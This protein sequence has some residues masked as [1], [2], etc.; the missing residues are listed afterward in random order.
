MATESLEKM[1]ST[2]F[3]APAKAVVEAER[4]YRKIWAEWLQMTAQ[5]VGA[6]NVG[7]QLNL[8]PVMKINGA[9]DLSLS[10]RVTS[11]DQTNASLSLG[12]GP[13]TVSGGYFRQTTEESSLS[14][15]GCFT[16]TNTEV[17]LASYLGQMG[18]TIK[19]DASCK[20]AIDKL[21][22]A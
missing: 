18:V 22:Q 11:I 20:Q 4:E 1:I 19:D 5:R 2:L 12:T 16:L 10:M 15:R 8:A 13:I 3:T 21:K 17:D 6:D 14:V 9:L 7:K